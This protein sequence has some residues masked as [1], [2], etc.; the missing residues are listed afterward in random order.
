MPSKPRSRKRSSEKKRGKRGPVPAATPSQVAASAA[1]AVTP[2]E[3]VKPQVSRVST[4]GVAAPNFSYVA[5]ELRRIAVVTG[6][7]LALLIIL[8]IFLR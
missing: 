7:V 8:A 6:I 3:A 2:P 1:P 4:P 5:R